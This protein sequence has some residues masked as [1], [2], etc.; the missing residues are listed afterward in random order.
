[1]KHISHKRIS[2]VSISLFDRFDGDYAKMLAISN[3]ATGKKFD[4]DFEEINDRPYTNWI[5]L[6]IEAVD[7]NERSLRNAVVMQLRKHGFKIQH[8]ENS[9]AWLGGGLSIWITKK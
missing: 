7:L 4:V 3:W 8:E 9:K 2:S 6:G 1:M 5:S